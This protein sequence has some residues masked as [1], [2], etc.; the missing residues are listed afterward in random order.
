MAQPDLRTPLGY[1]DR[2]MMEVLYAT[3]VR[4]AEL[5]ALKVPD[6]DLKRK[7]LRVRHGKGGK[8]R[9]APLST[10]CCRFL[11]RYLTEIRPE[12]IEGLRPYGNNWIQKEGTA[13]DTVFASVYGGPFSAGWLGQLMER[14]IRKAGITRPISPVHGFRHSV[15][16]V[17]SSVMWCV[18]YVFG[19]CPLSFGLI[20][21][22]VVNGTETLS[23]AV[24]FL[25]FSFPLR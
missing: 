6:M 13:G 23:A 1:R 20:P 11:D 12:L 25:F 16:Y 18:R 14:Y 22:D 2:T 19:R 4:A 5:L 15:A 21:D 17:L 7:V 10:P 8:D 9:F 24:G 3:G